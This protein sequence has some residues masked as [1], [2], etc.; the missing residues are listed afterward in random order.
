MAGLIYKDLIIGKKSIFLGI[1]I[2]VLTMSLLLIIPIFIQ[3]DTQLGA[4]SITGLF[5][6]VCFGTM[7]FVVGTMMGEGIFQ[8]D[9]SK[10]WAYFI[11]STP[12]L[13]AGHIKSKYILMLLI[14]SALMV[15]CDILSMVM[16]LFGCPAN[17]F[18][19]AI[20]MYAML[21]MSAVEI[22]FLVRFGSKV[23]SNVKTAFFM[24][25]TLIAFEIM[26]FGDTS[27]FSSPDKFFSFIE[28]ISDTSKMVDTVL[29]I[30]A[31]F[32]Y[33]SA[34]LYFLSYKISCKLYLRG[35][36]EYVK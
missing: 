2:V 21:F 31:A 13:A 35:A 16:A 9:E 11:V 15:W 18:F 23:G 24:L 20:M 6:V 1:G 29:V 25:L 33:V 10:K 3:E 5:S 7:F 32:P 19:A 36:E 22:P 4:E 27:I 34:A 14:Y 26:F 17:T 8:P 30:M 28:S 12:S